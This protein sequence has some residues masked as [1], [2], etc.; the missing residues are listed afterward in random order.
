MNYFAHALPFLDEPYFA[1]GTGVPDWL[2]V[3]DRRVRVRRKHA[4]PLAAEADEVTAAVARGVVQH[5]GDDARFHEGRGFVEL[6]LGLTAR[7]REV[8]GEPSGYRP[9]FL[10]HVLVE[11]LLDASL[12]AEEPARL[13]AYYRVL[14]GVDG[15]RIEGAV[16]RMAARPTARLAEMISR[17]C[18]ARIL[19]DYLEDAK[20]LGRLNQ[21]MRRVGFA[22][23]PETF[24]EVLPEARR[25]V[26]DRKAELL[27]GIPVAVRDAG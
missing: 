2:S 14:D 15:A 3:V 21:V 16:N 12:I 11:V 18:Q 13:E 9:P 6:S 17:F 10:G 26:A 19:W 8:L 25:Q 4:E 7:F 22:Q 24:C 27:A 20:L 5:L 23:L 1:A